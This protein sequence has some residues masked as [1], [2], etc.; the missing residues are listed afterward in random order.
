MRKIFI[1]KRNAFTLL[2]MVVSISMIAMVTV[3]F[4]ANYKTANKRTD[5][6]MTAQSLVADMHLAQNNALGLVKYNE[7]VPAG[8][9]G[10][11]FDVSKNYYTLFADLEA[12]GE[13]GYMNINEATEG[14]TEYGGRTTFLPA[15][16]TISRLTLS[17][18][19]ENNAV[20]VTFL[21]PDPRT[22][23]Y[24]ISS[25]ATTSAVMVELKE[26]RNNSVKTVRINFLGLAEVLD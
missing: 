12:P 1:G 18:G 13:L 19:V 7:A 2:E 6:I 15:G 20:N 23:I 4:I 22:N 5:L 26:G 10:I 16:I 3:L 8:G 9:W 17:G 25:G 24:S 21:P 14:V 11:A